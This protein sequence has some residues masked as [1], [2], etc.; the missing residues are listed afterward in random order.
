[1]PLDNARTAVV[2]FHVEPWSACVEEMRGLWLEH[3]REVALDQDIVPLDMDVRRYVEAEAAGRLHLVT[4]RRDGVLIGYFVAFVQT[5]LHYAS[6]IFATCDLF[7]LR[8]EFRSGWR[9]VTLFRVAE[10]TLRERGAV[11]LQAATKVH[12]SPVTGRTLDIGP[13]LERLGWTQSERTFRK[14]LV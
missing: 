14:R 7:Y 2:S 4:A 3:W 9:G 1:M 12:V 10:R 8:P 13:I 5:H 6:T 11:I